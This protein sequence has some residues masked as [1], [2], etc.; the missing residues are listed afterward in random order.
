M[1]SALNR[2]KEQVNCIQHLCLTD[3]RD[4]KKRIEEAKGGLLHDSYRWIFNN[5]D[6]Q[7]WHSAQQ[8]RLL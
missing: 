5:S 1:A 6:F 4:D 2:L 8:S 7:Q 3:P